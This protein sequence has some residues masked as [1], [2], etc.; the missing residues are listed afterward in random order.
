MRYFTLDFQSGA[1]VETLEKSSEM[2]QNFWV[3]CITPIHF[4][5]FELGL[6]KVLDQMAL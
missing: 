1:V 4:Q 2:M 6:Q 3:I 5:C